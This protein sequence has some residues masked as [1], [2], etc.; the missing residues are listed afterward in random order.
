VDMYEVVQVNIQVFQGSAVTH[1]R[2]GGK[3][4]LIFF[5]NSSNVHQHYHK[6]CVGV[7]WLTMFIA[8]II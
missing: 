1:M 2:R 8:H 4:Y 6:D 3:Y 5:C 7:F